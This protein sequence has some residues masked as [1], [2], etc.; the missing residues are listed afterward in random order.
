MRSV[1]GLNDY[2]LR[3]CQ[4]VVEKVYALDDTM[5]TPHMTSPAA[6]PRYQR[7]ISYRL[8]AWQLLAT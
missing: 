1:F 6:L 3:R 8:A 7:N 5:K 2:Q 4:G